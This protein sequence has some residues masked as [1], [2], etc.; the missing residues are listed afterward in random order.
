MGVE[1]A[2]R[3]SGIGTRA[4]RVDLAMLYAAHY[5]KVVRLAAFLLGSATHAEDIA[6][7][8]FIKIASARLDDPDKAFAYLQRIV[9]NECRSMHRHWAVVG[10]HE[11]RLQVVRHQQSAEETVRAAFDRSE[12]VTALRE[13][14]PRKRQVVVL[15]HYCDLS[16]R[17]V[18]DLL[19][20]SVGAVKS[21]TSRALA[22]LA[23]SLERHHG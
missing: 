9:V 13:L 23:I 22:D 7:D 4:D 20:I 6:Q 18:A 15:R 21:A 1:R 8:A 16:E 11:R 12:L 2:R 5:S 19:G 10:R 17:E 3:Q 14:S